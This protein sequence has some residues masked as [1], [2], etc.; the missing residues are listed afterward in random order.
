MCDF[1]C[2]STPS[3]PAH[4]PLHY[5]SISFLSIICLP[6]TKTT[7]RLSTF[8]AKDSHKDPYACIL[9]LCWHRT[10]W[11]F[12]CSYC[13]EFYIYI[14]FNCHVK[15]TLT[16]ISTAL[17]DEEKLGEDQIRLAYLSPK[18]SLLCH[19]LSVSNNTF[20]FLGSYVCPGALWLSISQARKA[21]QEDRWV[22]LLQGLSTNK[23]LSSKVNL[24]GEAAGKWR[25]R[26]LREEEMILRMD[27][28]AL[29]DKDSTVKCH[30]AD[31]C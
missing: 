22:S 2:H 28:R 31:T 19:S 7:A 10:L 26:A 14:L 3:E 16:T 5:N 13:V 18:D 25:Q 24:S 21:I 4:L 12:S 6:S 11:T 17:K 9:V 30:L 15:C 29:S 27:S 23:M 20:I 1:S 8:Q